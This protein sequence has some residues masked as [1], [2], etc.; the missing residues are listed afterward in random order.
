MLWSIAL[1]V[2][3][4]V[5]ICLTH[6]ILK[7]RNPKCNEV[8]PPGSMGLPFIGE[9][10]QLIIPSH[11]LDVAQFIKE[12]VQRHGCAADPEFNHFIL[13]QDGKLVEAWYL[14][15]F[16]KVFKQGENKA[17]R[18]SIHKYT[19]KISL[20]HFGV[21]SLK[22]KL[23]PKIEEM[24][25][26][27]LSS[28][29]SQECI[30]VKYATS[31]MT[32][33][34][35]AKQL[36]SYDDEKSPMNFCDKFINFSRGLMS[37]PLNIPGT[38]YYK[39]LEDYNKTFEMLANVVQERRASP[40]RQ[41]GDVLDHVI[42]DMNVEKFLTE[43]VVVQLMFGLL[44]VNFDSLSSTLTLVFKLLSENP[45]VLEEL[46]VTENE[47]ILRRREKSDSPITW[48]EYKSM[49]FTLHVVNE[50]LRLGSAAPGFLRR[51]RQDIQVNG[52]TIPAGWAIMVA[53]SAL[54]LNPDTYEDP[55]AF[56]PSRWKDL[57][58]NVI[59]KNFMPFGGGMKQCAGAEYSRVLL[60]IFLHVLVT[61]YRWTK[62]KG[63]NIVRNPILQFK[64]SIH[65]KISKKHG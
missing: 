47:A 64:D 21:E 33:D 12:R 18:A 36:F 42:E 2:I 49:T 11:S 65:I 26:K 52:Y 19:R 46:T 23:L 9:T 54:Q 32:L 27:T 50:T 35:G 38:A 34:F 15:L 37:F 22:G 45:L 40:D 1:C 55:P 44:F 8:L 41:H 25:H 62:I 56:N 30:E 59:A 20:N 48:E 5:I 63:G 6:F 57:K 31:V 7:W 28:W 60:V 39:C 58:A 16:A 17:D 14:D 29:S 13:L 61:K 4:L 53:A 51:A 43:D 3:A 24:V 10:I